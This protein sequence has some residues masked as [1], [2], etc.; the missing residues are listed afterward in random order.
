MTS[1]SPVCKAWAELGNHSSS[2][3][4]SAL[5]SSYSGRVSRLT[6]QRKVE[7]STMKI[8]Q[9]VT[10]MAWMRRSATAFT[11]VVDVAR[12][13][14]NCAELH[15]FVQGLVTRLGLRLA[16]PGRRR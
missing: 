11:R 13:G 6:L 15:E 2:A 9:Q 8:S 5:S 10:P 1:T 14:H 4:S 7:P 3:G 12:L 16:E